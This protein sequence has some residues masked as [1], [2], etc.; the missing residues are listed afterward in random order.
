MNSTPINVPTIAPAISPL[1]TFEDA[2]PGVLEDE[3][4]LISD[5][6]EERGWVFCITSGVVSNEGEDALEWEI[7]VLVL[8]VC[9]LESDTLVTLF[10]GSVQMHKSRTNTYSR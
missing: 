9:V 7:E 4:G 8:I 2:G 10:S 5:W 3:A 1:E 6:A